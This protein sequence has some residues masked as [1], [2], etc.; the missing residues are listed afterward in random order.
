MDIYPPRLPE[1]HSFNDVL[2]LYQYYFPDIFMTASDLANVYFAAGDQSCF[3]CL[4]FLL[5]LSC[6]YLVQRA[7]RDGIDQIVFVGTCPLLIREDQH[8]FYDIDIIS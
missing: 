2:N 3:T 4:L 1:N 7:Y 5:L 6:S 8:I